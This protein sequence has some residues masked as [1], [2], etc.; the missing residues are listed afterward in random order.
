MKKSLD[1][2]FSTAKEIKLSDDEKQV[3][4][5]AVSTHVRSHPY[6]KKSPI[7]S[8]V[9]P[10]HLG[11]YFKRQTKDIRYSTSLVAIL[12][13]TVS[14]GTTFAA[15]GALPGDLLYPVKVHVNENVELAVAFTPE[16][17]V[18][19]KTKHALRRLSEAEELY[20]NG[21]LDATTTREIKQRFEESID[22]VDMEISKNKDE[23]DYEKSIKQ[24]KVIVEGLR[25]SSSLLRNDNDNEDKEDVRDE[26]SATTTVSSTS[27]VMHLDEKDEK[28]ER[29]ILVESVIKRQEHSK[30]SVRELEEKVRSKIERNEKSEKNSG[31]GSVENKDQESK[32]L[33]GE[34]TEKTKST[35]RDEAREEE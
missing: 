2:I 24:H 10:Y 20:K 12:I 31:R 26:H 11:D 28:D 18:E 15:A 17:K 19:T 35:S 7:F 22:Q 30:R 21:Q 34:G 5:G 8:V 27:S 1:T 6:T 4:I 32:K 29:K 16:A 33:D 3:L 13:V 9:S 23:R 25:T 14:F